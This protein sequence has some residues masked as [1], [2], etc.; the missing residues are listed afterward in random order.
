MPDRAQGRRLL[1]TA[2]V[3][4]AIANAMIVGCSTNSSQPPDVVTDE[5]DLPTLIRRYPE[6][7]VALTVIGGELRFVLP[8]CAGVLAF[9][10][11]SVGPH[12]IAG[13]NSSD[14]SL[15]DQYW[16][17]HAD[18]DDRVLGIDEIVYKGAVP[19]GLTESAYKGVRPA[20]DAVLQIAAIFT[21][22][23]NGESVEFLNYIRFAD[24]EEGF[25]AF[26]Q[27]DAEGSEYEPKRMPLDEHRSMSCDGKAIP[28]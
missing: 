12:V 27:S 16:G 2:M 19:S 5:T 9:D 13:L 28:D 18:V 7:P 6:A 22:P 11:L 26:G 8:A 23:S 20:D 25:A 10:S 15:M 17:I 21:D 14:P 1:H 4:A 24:A 3:A